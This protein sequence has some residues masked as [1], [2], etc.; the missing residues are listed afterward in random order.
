VAVL[1][2]AIGQRSVHGHRGYRYK[3]KM[4]KRFS[5]RESIEGVTATVKR[6]NPQNHRKIVTPSLPQADREGR[7]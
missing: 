7:L 6:E 3:G 2:K 1:L 5:I 4:S